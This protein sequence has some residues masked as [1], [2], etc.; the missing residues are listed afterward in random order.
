VEYEENGLLVHVFVVAGTA[1]VKKPMRP[2][3]LVLRFSMG[4]D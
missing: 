2:M 4:L 3:G 1:Q